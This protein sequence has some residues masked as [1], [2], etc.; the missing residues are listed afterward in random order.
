MKLRHDDLARTID[1]SAK[2]R[3]ERSFDRLPTREAYDRWAQV[4]DQQD[5]PLIALEERELPGLLG[6]L[7]G[8]D[9]LDVGCGTGRWTARLVASGARVTG[10]DFSREMLE[11][12][13]EQVKAGEVTLVEHDLARPLPLADSSY[14]LV[15][16]AL[17][18]EHIDDLQPLFGE[19]A[20]VCRPAGRVVVSEMHPAMMLLDCQ[21]EFSDPRTGRDVRPV[22]HV[23]PV[24]DFVMAARGAGLTV[25]HASEHEVDEDLQRRSPRAAKF[26]GWP[27]LLLLI[28]RA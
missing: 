14:E 2:R 27:L 3:R 7:S 1:R 20:R 15:L 5:N 21:A 28:F 8:L 11:R 22:S 17:V 10:I 6:H 23:H 26:A 19:L 9:A 18:M 4:Y 24:S 25:E 12:S 16:S 13:R